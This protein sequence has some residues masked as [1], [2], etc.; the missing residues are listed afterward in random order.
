MRVTEHPTQPIDA[1]IT[2]RHLRW[3][4]SEDHEQTAFEPQSSA[5][6]RVDGPLPRVG[7]LWDLPAHTVDPTWS[8]PAW[9]AAAAHQHL[10]AHATG[11]RFA[12]PPGHRQRKRPAPGTATAAVVA[13][14]VS[15]PL[16]L[17]GIGAI[18]G[19][20]GVVLGIAAVVQIG[21]GPERRQGTGRA[22]TA[23]VAGTASVIVGTP[24]LLV[25]L[26]VLAV[27]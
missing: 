10:P 16:A 5:A 9:S 2:D 6:T 27:I 15:L 14:S 17:L 13:S 1:P 18:L 24:I 11:T 7:E 3:P 25:I 12:L 20:V 4:P 8:D 19:F 21:S 22:V 23:I 26:A